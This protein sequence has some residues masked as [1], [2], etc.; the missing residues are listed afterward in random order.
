[1]NA[2]SAQELT[3]K[4]LFETEY[5]RLC[6]YALSYMQDTHLAED[7]VQE[8]FIRIWEQKK[9]MIGH[10]NIRFYLV[11]AVKNNCIS[12]LR[13]IKAEQTQLTADTPEPEPEV[14]LT[15]A[16]HL[17]NENSK[18]KQIETALNLLP[19]KCKE[20]FLMI[21][22]HGM[23]YKEAAETLNISV[24]TIENQMGKALKTLRESQLLPLLFGLTIFLLKK[25]IS[26]VGV[27]IL[28]YVL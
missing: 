15:F 27:F 16:Q 11:A 18:A 10:P 24:K 8:T 9:E 25:Y 13:K 23:S 20:V 26:L 17:E 14:H 22:L 28:S 1:M 6:R 7:I 4:T 5:V 21:K 2:L 12:A 3:F 19:P